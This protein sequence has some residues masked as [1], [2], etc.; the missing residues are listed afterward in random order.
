[1][2]WKRWFNYNASA[3]IQLRHAHDEAPVAMVHDNIRA[4]PP[5]N[6]AVGLCDATDVEPE[7]ETQVQCIAVLGLLEPLAKNGVLTVRWEG[8]GIELWLHGANLAHSE[9]V[10]DASH[11]FVAPRLVHRL[12]AEEYP[13]AWSK[14][15]G[16]NWCLDDFHRAV[17]GLPDDAAAHHLLEVGL[18]FPV[19]KLPPHT[20]AQDKENLQTILS[21]QAKFANRVAVPTALPARGQLHAERLR[22]HLLVWPSFK[23]LARRVGGVPVGCFRYFSKL[24]SPRLNS[25]ERPTFVRRWV[26]QAFDG[27]YNVGVCPEAI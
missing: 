19:D 4:R 17:R 12:D 26:Q 20:A 14:A 21:Y 10:S 6:A 3:V 2:R 5:Q 18:A 27:F 23:Q 16:S 9:H 8:E 11:L 7:A 25:V 24:C 15:R 1:M 22:H 13:I